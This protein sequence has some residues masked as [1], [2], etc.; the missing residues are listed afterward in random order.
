MLSS[1]FAQ[2]NNLIN[3]AINSAFV[4]IWSGENLSLEPAITQYW[5]TLVIES[6]Y[7]D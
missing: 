2:S 6:L 5:Q 3:I 4:T 1:N 7:S